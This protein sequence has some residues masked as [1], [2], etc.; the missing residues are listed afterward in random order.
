LK[1]E[2]RYFTINTIAAGSGGKYCF[3]DQ[4]PDGITGW[5]RFT[6]G[7]PFGDA[8][9]DNAG[10]VGLRLAAD[11]RGLQLPSLIGNTIG[12]LPV[13]AKTAATIA[14]HNVGRMEQLP[15]MLID[16]KGRVYSRDYVILNPLE[17]IDCLNLE[18]S[19]VR[20]SY[21]GEIREV[22]R[23]VLDKTKEGELIDLFRM[24]EEPSVYLFSEVL[25][26]ALEKA[27]STN[28]RFRPVEWQ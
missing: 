11:A 23:I 17:R 9:P 19:Q 1:I 7:E 18:A 3:T 24:G 27:G 10:D 28:L 26:S 2:M 25:T 4:T 20:R 6:K 12:M 16:H 5:Y 15:F 8:Y 14:A 22:T 21:K 13:D